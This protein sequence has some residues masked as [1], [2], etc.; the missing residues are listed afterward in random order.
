M[1]STQHCSLY[2][3][4]HSIAVN[5]ALQS[6]LQSTQHCSLYC[7]QHS[8]AVC[9]AVNTALQSVLQSTQ[10]CSL[11]CSQHSI[12]VCIA[13]NTALQSALQS[14]QQCSAELVTNCN[15][16]LLNS[17]H[18]TDNNT[19]TRERRNKSSVTCFAA[20]TLNYSEKLCVVFLVK[21]TLCPQGTR[22]IT[23]S[24]P[25]NPTD[26]EKCCYIAFR[27]MIDYEKKCA[28]IRICI[29]HEKKWYSAFSLVLTMKVEVE[30]S[31]TIV[32][33]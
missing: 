25:L 1:Q 2:C 17:K 29:G 8:I 26:N 12:A 23:K 27:L 5:T 4:Q 30:L 24:E 19:C 21:N 18:C 11:H 16:S 13:V 9:I 6:L 15:M 7:S 33:N 31:M 20:D 22:I 3:S 10:H 28:A 32:T 14:T